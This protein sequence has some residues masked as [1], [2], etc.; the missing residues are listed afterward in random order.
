MQRI[1]ALILISLITLS[2]SNELEFNTPA[3]QGTKD[4]GSWMADNFQAI[5]GDDGSLKII[6][7]RN[8]ETLTISTENTNAGTYSLGSSSANSAV[9]DGKGFVTYS[10]LNNG[11][12]E[13]IIKDFDLGNLTI[14]G[15]FKFNAYSSSGEIV[16]FIQGVF[17]KIPIAHNGEV[18]AFIGSNLFEATVNSNNVEVA[19]IE[20]NISDTAILQIKAKNIDGTYIEIFMP[21]ALSIGSHN[22]NFSTQIYANYVTSDGTIA[23][24][25]YGTLT[26]LE[27][28]TLFNKIKATFLFNSGS[29]HNIEISNGNFIVYY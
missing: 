5:I 28:D 7:I 6:A 3:F 20:T 27:H 8:T 29:P 21:E 12:G 15:A 2:C 16:N 18:M 24:S 22:L 25:Q 26:I 17:H 14:T 13:I 4:Y 11:D 19:T 1:I 10:T 9:F 23:S